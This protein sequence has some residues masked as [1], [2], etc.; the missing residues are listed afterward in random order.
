[1]VD[2]MSKRVLWE[3]IGG[4]WD[5]M[6]LDS[7]SLDPAESGLASLTYARTQEATLGRTVVMPSNYA[8]RD[9]G[10]T[11]CKYVVTHRMELGD[12]V[13]VRLE[14]CPSDPAESCVCMMKRI[15]LE[16]HGGHLDG[17]TLDSQSDDTDEALLAVA[18]YCI[19]SQGTVGETLHAVPVAS[20]LTEFKAIRTHR[21]GEYGVTYRREQQTQ[22]LVRLAHQRGGGEPIEI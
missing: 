2:T 16:F 4:A 18:Y 6:N 8:K 13:L 5:A 7:D 19:T 3:F 15:V 1:M 11:G 17:R 20:R 21:D 22:V 10:S 9:I 14:Y 12:E